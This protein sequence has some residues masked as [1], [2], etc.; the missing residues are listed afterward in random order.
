MTHDDDLIDNK[1][2]I[3][4]ILPHEDGVDVVDKRVQLFG[5]IPLECKRFNFPFVI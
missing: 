2:L 4:D 1:D 5:T 3:L